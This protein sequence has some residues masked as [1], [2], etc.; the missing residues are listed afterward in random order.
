VGQRVNAICRSFTCKWPLQLTE[1]LKQLVSAVYAATAGS[2][3]SDFSMNIFPPDIS[4]TGHL[5]G[6][7]LVCPWTSPWRRTIVCS[8][9]DIAHGIIEKVVRQWPTQILGQ[10]LTNYF[11]LFF[12]I[13][14]QAAQRRIGL[15]N[16]GHR[17]L[18]KIWVGTFLYAAYISEEWF[19]IVSNGKKWKLEIP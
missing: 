18:P 17:T 6:T 8:R 3:G 9:Y 19:W 13:G 16:I 7:F 14:R 10:S 11:L 5:P 1:A 12:H 15:R 2:G 4:P